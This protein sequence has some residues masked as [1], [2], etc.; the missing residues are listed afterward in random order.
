MSMCFG[1]RTRGPGALFIE[2]EV[3]SLSAIL[4]HLV[5]TTGIYGLSLV[6]KWEDVI[7]YDTLKQ[8][9]SSESLSLELEPA[10]SA[11]HCFDRWRET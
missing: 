1:E 11:T 7:T 5:D 8:R 3:A 2:T 4:T 10:I 6:L 9:W